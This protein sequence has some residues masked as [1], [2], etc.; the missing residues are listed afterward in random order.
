MSVPQIEL[1][2]AVGDEDSACGKECHSD[3]GSQGRGCVEKSVASGKDEH[4]TDCQVQVLPVPV[5]YVV[6][7]QCHYSKYLYDEQGCI[8]II[9]AGNEQGIDPFVRSEWQKNCHEQG[10]QKHSAEQCCKGFVFCVHSHHCKAEES[11]HPYDFAEVCNT[12]K[13]KDIGLRLVQLLQ[14]INDGPY[15]VKVQGKKKDQEEEYFCP[16]VLQ[17]E[18]ADEEY[19]EYREYDGY[20]GDQDIRAYDHL[21]E[22]LGQI[23]GKVGQKTDEK[24][25]EDSRENIEAGDYDIPFAQY[26]HV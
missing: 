8:E 7:N 9:K 16:G 13:D 5:L 1:V 14:N 24:H 20:A 26:S 22:G 10:Q 25:D 23:L 12:G 3:Y 21:A 19:G 15:A 2:D 11:K 17:E 4:H 6:E 18:L